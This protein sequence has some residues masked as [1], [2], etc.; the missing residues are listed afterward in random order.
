MKG[1][2]GDDEDDDDEGGYF[3]H[4]LFCG[5]LNPDCPVILTVTSTL[6][7]PYCNLLQQTVQHVKFRCNSTMTRNRL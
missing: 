2:Q 1:S 6:S 3:L 4:A 7:P 5:Y